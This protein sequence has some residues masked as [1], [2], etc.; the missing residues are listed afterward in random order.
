MMGFLGFGK[1]KPV[2]QQPSQPGFDLGK[3]DSDL[4][5]ISAL[6]PLESL[7]SLDST[8]DKE[9]LP[10]FGSQ[11]PLPPSM[12]APITD[13]TMTAQGSQSAQ[14]P[15]MPALNFS[16]PDSDEAR[17]DVDEELNKLFLSDDWKEPDWNS[18]DPYSLPDIE[19]PDPK[20]FGL[21]TY[22]AQDA[23]QN[24]VQDVS[25]QVIEPSAVPS[26]LPS[27]DEQPV[28]ERDERKQI[29]FELYV[30][31][32]HYDAVF[33]E[34]TKINEMLSDE[35]PNLDILVNY[36]KSEDE[37]LGKAKDNMEY[38]YRKM[39]YVDKKIFA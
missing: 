27:F 17:T 32:S 29:P 16:M 3:L 21:E 30:R 2:L 39:M 12:P 34:L 15:D 38:I 5:S 8:P 18:F 28:V 23:E 31:G 1:K 6:P 4:P 37:A 13:R 11:N 22:E 33:T 25:G 19:P 36:T 24:V 26:D 9:P 10:S 14:A 35:G 7:P 20:D